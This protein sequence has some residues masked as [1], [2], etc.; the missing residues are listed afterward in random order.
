MNLNSVWSMN[1]RNVGKGTKV[2]RFAARA[3]RVFTYIPCKLLTLFTRFF[4]VRTV[5]ASIFGIRGVLVEG[6]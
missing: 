1:V 3:G 4:D 2:L 6:K 5:G